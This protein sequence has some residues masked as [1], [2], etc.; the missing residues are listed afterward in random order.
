MHTTRID[1]CSG[2]AS[3][4]PDG[5]S[6]GMPDNHALREDGASRL[7][8]A[9]E[10][11]DTLFRGALKLLQARS[12]YRFCL[13]SLLL[14]D[15]TTCREGERIADL[16]AGNG[17]VALMLAYLYPRVSI[18]GVEIQPTI[19]ERA[20]RNVQMNG[21]QERVTIHQ[22]DVRNIQEILPG[23]SCHAV[24]C[25]PPYRRLSS[26]RI[27]P[28]AEKK[29]ARHE[30]AGSLVD[31]LR[32]G[33]Y[34]MPVKGRMTLIYPAARLVDLLQSMRNAA[35][36]PKRV[37]MVHSFAGAPASLVLAEGVK[38]GRS[39]MAV[40]APLV[41]YDPGRKYTEAVEAI[42]AGAAQCPQ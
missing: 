40:D 33:V 26:G 19:V 23:G 39:G 35:L 7:K 21:L 29:I 27:S 6:E 24:V 38:G 2:H 1:E 17:V 34:L 18:V 22:G 28:N 11:V 12:G 16:G 31:F 9:D 3:A 25:N 4:G 13:D 41:I 42:L 20:R 15:F 14:A 8:R 5:Q 32:A 36:E 10:T 30:T 37:R